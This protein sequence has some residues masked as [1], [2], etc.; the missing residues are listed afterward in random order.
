MQK[1]HARLMSEEENIYKQIFELSRD[2]VVILDFKATIKM[3]NNRAFETYGYTK[4]EMIGMNA[5]NLTHPNFHPVFEK[6]FKEVNSSGFS[7]SET[8]EVKKDG[9]IFNAEVDG[10]LVTFNNKPHLMSIIRDISDKIEVY[11]KLKQSEERHK[12]ITENLHDAIWILSPDEKITYISQ[13]VSQLR[14]YTPEEVMNQ[15]MEEIVCPSSLPLVYG[16]IEEF[17]SELAKGNKVDLKAFQ[18]EQPCKDGSTV[19]T[20]VNVK[21]IFDENNNFM[22]FLGV[23][24]DIDSRIKSEEEN[25]QLK[26]RLE[27]Q[28]NRMPIGMIVWDKNF[29]IQ[30]WNPA[31]EEIFGYTKE[32][33]I[34]VHPFDYLVPQDM[35]DEINLI[36][37]RLLQGDQTAHNINDNLTKSGECITCHWSN[38]PLKDGNGNI[39]GALSMVQNITNQQ[40][41]EAELQNNRENLEELV[42]KRTKEIEDQSKKLHDSQMA[43][44]FLLEDINET[45]ADL[46]AA[47]KKLDAVNKELEAFSYSVSHDLRAPLNRMNGFSNA[48]LE[49]YSSQLDEKGIHYLKR[50]RA[51]SQHMSEL[52]NDILNLSKIS[53]RK[54][55]PKEI[56]ISEIVTNILKELTES[57]PSRKINFSIKKNL[58]VKADETLMEIFLRNLLENAWK[59]CSRQDETK[60]ALDSK[61][62]K[63]EI[64]IFIKDN[65]VGFDMKYYD[66]LFQPFRRLHPEN[67]FTGTGIGLATAQRII[68]RHKGRIWAESEIGEGTT[69][70]FTI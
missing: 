18:V 17:Y 34:G 24:R 64:I 21:P 68:N 12:L 26:E 65:G 58:H 25:R 10:S 8:I 22:Y 44:T 31:A 23:S 61:A 63:D 60:I 67:E 20:E 28:I 14:G 53:R 48:L 43:L 32:E 11:E 2:C 52:I 3:A 45:R 57:D 19:W 42:K 41:V 51:S 70:F 16:M 29:K 37:E 59:F 56:N 66:Q 15:K 46:E 39:I 30:S 6:F 50:I 33:I 55:I 36:W 4:K 1:I 38:T 54:I 40:L 62:G 35:Q 69:F 49:N 13:S 7:K 47:N 5:K 27:L 9:T